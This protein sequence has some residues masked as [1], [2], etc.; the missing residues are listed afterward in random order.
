VTAAGADAEPAEI[1]PGLWRWTA[2]HPEWRP[3][4]AAGS[5]ADW[6]AEVGSV[7]VEV[8][9]AAVFIDALVP[10]ALWAW[11]DERCAA[12]AR[13]LALTTIRFHRRSRSELVVRYRAQTSR[14]RAE[15]PA[16]IE[17][18]PLRGA[19]EVDFWLAQRRTLIVGDRLLGAVGGG[20]R[21]CP[22]SWLRYLE[23]GMT[24]SGLR[25]RLRPLLD[26]PI[27]RVLV[28]HGEPVLSD[29]HEALAEALR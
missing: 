9:G 17:P 2:R 22:E 29:G 12:A 3:G 13:V 6:P 26:L 25:D 28:S 20:L 1:E 5:P 19:G 8:A 27:E 24:L 10:A 15:L 7:L 18:V 21:L 23:T 11:A 16:G 4:A 14:A